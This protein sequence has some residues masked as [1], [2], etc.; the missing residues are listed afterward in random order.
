MKC[1]CI[2]N[3]YTCYECEIKK[4]WLSLDQQTKMDLLEY[5]SI[6]EVENQ[7]PEQMKRFFVLAGEL[8][9]LELGIESI[10]VDLLPELK[11]KVKTIK[12][13]ED[14]QEFD[15]GVGVN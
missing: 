10:P 15:F 9:E 12:F 7:T 3:V 11:A 6:L 5:M 8:N 1:D 2:E 4:D 14:N 13:S